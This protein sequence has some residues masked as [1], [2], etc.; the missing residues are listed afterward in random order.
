MTTTPDF[1]VLDAERDDA[2]GRTVI[3][4]L[5]KIQPHVDEIDDWVTMPLRVAHTPLAGIVIEVGPYTLDRT[6]VERLHAALRGYDNAA[7]ASRTRRAQ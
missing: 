3:A 7:G 4:E 6:D 2:D 1:P 5:G